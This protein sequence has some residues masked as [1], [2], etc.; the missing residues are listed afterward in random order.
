M[1]IETK[2]QASRPTLKP[3]SPWVRGIVLAG[4]AAAAARGA[5]WVAQGQ[6]I[7]LGFAMMFFCLL[8]V[9]VAG[10]WSDKV[11]ISNSKLLT[12][13]WTVGGIGMLL[14]NLFLVYL[15]AQS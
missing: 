1:N 14:A 9:F 2:I 5:T 10:G 7:G 4:F 13:A 3:L 8:F 11:L 15:S 12:F 6:W